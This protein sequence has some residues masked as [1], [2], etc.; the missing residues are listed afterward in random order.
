MK[1]VH[2]A[3]QIPC[4]ECDNPAT[5]VTCGESKLGRKYRYRRCE[6]CGHKFKTSQSLSETDAEEAIIPYLETV[7][8]R[9]QE[10]LRGGGSSKLKPDDVREIR[11]MWIKAVYKDKQ[12][13]IH[14]AE[15]FNVKE[16]AVKNILTG[17]AWSFVP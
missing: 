4:P 1:R 3:K 2:T 11:A 14:I 5:R 8:L 16:R 6:A 7:L 15:R 10:R 12:E 13:M 17:K 9:R